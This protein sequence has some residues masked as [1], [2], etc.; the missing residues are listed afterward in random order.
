MAT[1]ETSYNQLV[2]FAK[3]LLKSKS[4]HLTADDLIN[5]AYLLT[6]SKKFNLDAFKKAM[7]DYL[8]NEIREVN[9]NEQDH[10]EGE[11]FED[12]RVCRL[13]NE[14]LPIAAFRV[15]KSELYEIPRN[16]CIECENK[17]RNKRRKIHKVRLIAPTM[18]N[19]MLYKMER[20]RA[21]IN[22]IRK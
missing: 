11:Q 2:T 3:D 20:A 19:S 9:K 7:R 22:S 12:S 14:V 13:C 6:H 18:T 21:I 10:K 1:F 5:E 8:F 15:R 17:L 4:V 16:E